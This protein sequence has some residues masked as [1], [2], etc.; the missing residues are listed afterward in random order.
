MADLGYVWDE[1]KAQRV[2]LKHGLSFSEV[3]QA[4]EDPHHIW[5]VDPQGHPTRFMIVGRTEAG[6]VLHVICAEE[7][8]PVIRLVT[9]FV[10]DEAWRTRYEG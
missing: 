2:A 5:D 10:A 3:V 8:M 6:K 1:D 4:A 9:A 7:Q